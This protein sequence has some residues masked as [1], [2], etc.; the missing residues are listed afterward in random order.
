MPL[1]LTLVVLATTA[2]RPG[3]ELD[4]DL[5]DD[6]LGVVELPL[7]GAGWCDDLEEV[8]G[9]DGGKIVAEVLGV[10][11]DAAQL[12]LGGANLNSL[13]LDPEPGGDLR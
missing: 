4:G 1:S 12:G 6:D 2:L 8:G 13:G 7:E 9:V 3:L 10:G 11:L 5:G